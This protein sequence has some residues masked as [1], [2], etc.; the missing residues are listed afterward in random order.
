M[1]GIRAR[2]SRAHGFAGFI[3]GFV[4]GSVAFVT[5]LVYWVERIGLIGLALVGALGFLAIVVLFALPEPMW[6]RLTTSPQSQART[7]A[8]G[9]LTALLAESDAV[10]QR[11]FQ[12]PSPAAQMKA[13]VAQWRTQ[14]RA[15]VESHAPEHQADFNMSV[16]LPALDY[17]GL[18]QEQGDVVSEFDVY[19]D[20]LAA[21]LA[22]VR[23]R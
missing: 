13:E 2:L 7:E 11:F 12:E 6:Q 17:T 20:R 15:A 23:R 16:S 14:A 8:I 3:V 19:R 9:A 21:I 18:L 5:A 22:E 4:V 1:R 10:R